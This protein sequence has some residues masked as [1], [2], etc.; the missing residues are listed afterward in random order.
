MGMIKDFLAR[1]RLNQAFQAVEEGDISRLGQLLKNK[2]VSPNA[3]RKAVISGYQFE[4]EETL[5]S[6]AVRDHQYPVALFLLSAGA[7][8]HM[9][10]W[11]V[12]D[13]T[14]AVIDRAVH[15]SDPAVDG[16]QPTSVLL[17]TSISLKLASALEHRKRQTPRPQNSANVQ[18]VLT[19]T[20]ANPELY[21]RK[22]QFKKHLAEAID[23]HQPQSAPPSI[24]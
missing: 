6:K 14:E 22:Q 17:E 5:L 1:R 4:W 12:G 16:S 24:K 15:F 18:I 9:G 13:L 23:G 10:D 3:S 20:D 2:G 21:E 8:P 7:N 11:V 19:E